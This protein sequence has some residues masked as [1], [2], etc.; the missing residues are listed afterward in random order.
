[1]R[2]SGRLRNRSRVIAVGVTSTVVALLVTVLIAGAI[3]SNRNTQG[4]RSENTA[5]INLLA[6]V[7][8]SGANVTIAQFSELLLA[9]NQRATIT[10]AGHAT[11]VGDSLRGRSDLITMTVPIKGGTLTLASPVD[12]HLD[13]P[14]E[15]VLITLGVLLVVLG[16]VALA[17]RTANLQTR[18]RVDEAVR[19]AERVS[20][21]DFT[22]R[23]GAGGPEVLVRLGAAFDAMASRLESI[24]H[25]QREFL[26][27]LA[28]EIATPIQ[29]LSGY[30]QGVIDG[31]I[32]LETASEAIENQTARLS[33]LLD[34]LAELRSL[35][36]PGE[37]KVDEVDLYAL[38]QGLHQEFEPAASAAGVE[39]ERRGAH[40]TLVTDQKLV[41]TVM[42]NFVTNALR[43]TPRGGRIVIGCDADPRQVVLSVADTGIG[44]APE[45][46]QR[47][48]DRFFRTAEAR[49]RIT[50]GTG[51]GLTIARRAAHSLGGHIELES[52]LGR[53]S[54]FRLVLPQKARTTK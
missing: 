18:R 49:D 6:R 1:M 31:T 47:I 48:F 42:S 53:G 12:N 32:P 28:H 2:A 11:V 3:G 34:E 38:V 19:A 27:D 26:A 52:E 15:I 41:T 35:D 30:S 21:G 24:D 43:Y 16:S 44:I 4:Q 13:P 39:L 9:K 8:D 14:L 23:I 37:S 40:V 10:V 20:Q 25:E 45:H 50:G 29:A 7:L 54:S 36:A 17:N 5:T 22:A 51:L 33:E 46:Q